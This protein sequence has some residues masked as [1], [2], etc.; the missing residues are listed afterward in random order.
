MG[1]VA[2]IGMACRLPGAETCEQF[3]TNLTGKKDCIRE[4]PPDRWDT[5]RY[6][7]PDP[8]QDGTSNSKWAGL[9]DHVDKFDHQL[10]GISSREARSMDPQ[11]RLL[12]EEA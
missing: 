4:I 9:L 5:N 12:L 7:S 2:V 1:A 10:F 8:A 11:Q 3:W 6:Y